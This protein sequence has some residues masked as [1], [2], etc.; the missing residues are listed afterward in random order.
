MNEKN[1]EGYKTEEI[2]KKLAK[3]IDNMTEKEKL[4]S[5]HRIIQLELIENHNNFWTAIAKKM[6]V[7]K[8]LRDRIIW[9]QSPD[10]AGYHC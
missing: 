10:M 4:F 3:E 6:L 5:L 8:E 1:S 7:S 2:I 9:V